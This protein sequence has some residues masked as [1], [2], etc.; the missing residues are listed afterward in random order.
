MTTFFKAL[1]GITIIFIFLFNFDQSSLSAIKENLTLMTLVSSCFLIVMSTIPTLVRWI[2]IAKKNY[3]TS[4]VNNLINFYYAGFFFNSVSP[5]NLGGDAYKFISIKKASKNNNEEIINILL[6]ERIYG[7]I[8]L[9]FIVLFALILSP[10]QFLFSGNVTEEP[11]ILFISL[12]VCLILFFKKRILFKFG[13]ASFLQKFTSFLNFNNTNLTYDLTILMFSFLGF[14][15]WTGAIYLI[16]QEL[17]ISLDFV[18]LLIVA[19]FVEIIRFVPL[20]FQG[21]GIREPSFALLLSELYGTNFEVAFLCGLIAYSCL[22]LINI[23]LGIIFYF[24]NN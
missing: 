4:N 3:I 1:I 20:T 5:A 14:L 22:S 7:L 9:I 24:F 8:S 10:N 11:I 2:F 15:F 12:S 23:L 21:I 13:Q 17:N 18:N 19:A 6:H 16:C